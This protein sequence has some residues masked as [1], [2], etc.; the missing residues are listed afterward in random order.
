MNKKQAENFRRI[1][2]T[3]W[4][5]A[6]GGIKHV[7]KKLQLS[8]SI[9]NQISQILHGYT[10][11]PRAARS[12]EIKL[13]IPHLLLD[14]FPSSSEIIPHPNMSAPT[15]HISALRT[16]FDANAPFN[17]PINVLIRIP[18]YHEMKRMYTDKGNPANMTA[19]KPCKGSA[20][21][22]TEMSVTSR[23]LGENT[24]GYT[25]ANNLR[26]VTGFGDSM[27]PIFK[28]GDLIIV[29]IGIKE[30]TSDNAYFFRV[31]DQTFIRYLLYVPD[32]GLRVIASNSLYETWV[33]R[34]DMDFEVLG[35]VLKTLASQDF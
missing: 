30:V 23:W 14:T 3:A 11:G 29:D 12:I 20:S 35:Q 5:N 2:L 7:S 31:E 9:V 24:R 13:N 22:I 33:I 4:L 25:S 1:T 21:A 28:S 8:Q 17:T 16:S 34:P 32:E 27:N 18:Q 19:W 6:H 26:I 15:K 10:F